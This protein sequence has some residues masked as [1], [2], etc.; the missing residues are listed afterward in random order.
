MFLH[1]TSTAHYFQSYMFLYIFTVLFFTIFQVFD[2]A[3]RAVLR[4]QPV[5]RRQRKCAIL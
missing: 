4:P 5:R 3:V 1:K 2:E